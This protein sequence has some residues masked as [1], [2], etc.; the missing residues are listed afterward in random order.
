MNI[1]VSSIAF[2][3]L[4]IQEIEQLA[5]ENDISIEFSANF[6]PNRDLLTQFQTSSIDRLPHNYFPPP[7]DPF[8]LNLASQNK[9]ILELS[10]N[11]CIQGIDLAMDCRLKYYSAHAGF[12][13]D[14]SP[15]SLGKKLVQP[16]HI[17]RETYWVTFIES[18]QILCDLASEKGVK[19]LIENNVLM[20]T[21]L[22][23][24]G[25]NPL[26]CVESEEILKVF[27]LVKNK[28]LGFLLDTAHLKVSAQSLGF[29]L[30]RAVEIL[31]DRI[32]YIHHSDNDAKC[33]TN[34]PITENYWFL[35]H[36]HSFKAI[37]H[38]VEVKNQTVGNLKQQIS[39]LE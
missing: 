9:R 36:M 13:L 26:L 27:E 5:I 33:D 7:V 22:R 18:C 35:K 32:D 14:P 39:L 31:K 6:H 1:F 17:D 12:C 37:P 19:F 23:S 16:D 15:E 30:E 24:D 8:V 2:N 25:V 38:V 21:N 10:R 29:D 4:S 34:E 3:N 11:H 28:S 20:E